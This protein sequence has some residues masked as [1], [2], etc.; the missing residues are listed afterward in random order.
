MSDGAREAFS[1]ALK[2]ITKPDEQEQDV[3]DEKKFMDAEWQRL[4]D[5]F[6]VSVEE[7]RSPE[8][9]K[10]MDRERD[11][12]AKKEVAIDKRGNS[13]VWSSI[14]NGGIIA[15]IV[16]GCVWR[17]ASSRAWWSA[18]IAGAI[19]AFIFIAAQEEE[20]KSV[21]RKDYLR[22]TEGYWKQVNSTLG[23]FQ[24]NFIIW[25]IVIFMFIWI[26]NL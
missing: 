16:A 9:E 7:L 11:E 26:A 2:R 3:F 21:E 19:F 10:R 8:F 25:T 22:N 20:I 1:R 23:R 15:G 6:G 5:D 12:R 17:L 4:A 14:R 18:I 24:M 13:K